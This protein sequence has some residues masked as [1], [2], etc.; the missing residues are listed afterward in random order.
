MYIVTLEQRHVEKAQQRSR[1]NELIQKRQ[2]EK[3]KGIKNTLDKKKTD[4]N[5]AH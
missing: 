4:S 3:K 5:V 1:R 2:E